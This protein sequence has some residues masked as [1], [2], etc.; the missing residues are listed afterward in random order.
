MKKILLILPL[1]F[2]LGCEDEKEED[3]TQ[4]IMIGKTFG[5]SGTDQGT[6][7]EQTTDDGYIITG[8]TESFGIGEDDVWLIK[9]DSNG[10]EEWNQTFGGS[11]YNWGWSVEQT[12]DGGFIITGYTESFGN[13][14]WDVWLIKT[15]SEGNTVPF[16]LWKR[17][18]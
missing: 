6:F 3:K 15:D 10:N 12:T 16:V 13:G 1:L 8:R 5:G 2:W 14:D 4:Q 7:I 11:S 17:P 18:A 9:T